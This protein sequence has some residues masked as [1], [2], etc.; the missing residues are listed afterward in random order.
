MASN[1]GKYTAI[2]NSWGIDLLD[3]S[4]YLG[5][6]EKSTKKEPKVLPNPTIGKTTLRFNPSNAGNFKISLFDSS[7]K[8]IKILKEEYLQSEEQRIEIDAEKLALGTYFVQIESEQGV[9][10]VSFVVA[11]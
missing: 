11:R 5:I 6:K 10:Y 8:E 4:K 2:G 9:E 3:F 1:D 7:M